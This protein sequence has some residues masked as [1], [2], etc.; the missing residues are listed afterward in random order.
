MRSAALPDKPAGISGRAPGLCVLGPEFVIL[1]ADQDLALFDLV[2]LFHADPLHPARDFGIQVDLVM[3]DDVTGG[4]K[5][6]ASDIVA[7]LRGS[8]HHFHF[9]NVLREQAVDHRH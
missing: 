7:L 9:R 5:N 8:A 1:K 4:G 3:G 6:H 2:A